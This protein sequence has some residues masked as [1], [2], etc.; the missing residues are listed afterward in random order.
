MTL[1]EHG[2]DEHTNKII[3]KCD[4]VMYDLRCFAGIQWGAGKSFLKHIY[5]SLLRSRVEFGIVAHG[6][7]AKSVLSEL[8][9]QTKVCVH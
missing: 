2:R 7:A 6:S 5:V 9:L 4:K 1:D 8:Q 3:E